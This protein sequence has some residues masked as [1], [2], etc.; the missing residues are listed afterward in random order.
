MIDVQTE[1]PLPSA[2]GESVTEALV[3][4][5]R[6]R[7]AKGIA[8]YGD[9]LRTHNGRDAL[10]DALD[11]AQYIMQAILERDAVGERARRLHAATPDMLHAITVALEPAGDT[12]EM[13]RASLI[14]AWQKATGMRHPERSA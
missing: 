1:Q 11:L 2:G 10:R 7:E 6:Q 9:T 3:G 4:L 5:I 8:T 14:E 12:P 13:V